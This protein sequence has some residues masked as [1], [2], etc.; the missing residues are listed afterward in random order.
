MSALLLSLKNKKLDISAMITILNH[1]YDLT[2]YTSFSESFTDTVS[3]LMRKSGFYL[4]FKVFVLNV[5]S[6]RIVRNL[7]NSINR[8]VQ[9]YDCNHLAEVHK[10]SE[11]VRNSYLNLLENIIRLKC[12]KFL[13]GHTEEAVA[14]W[15]D[16]VEDTLIGAD[17]EIRSLI[18]EIARRL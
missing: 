7:R 10:F 6:N 15:D 14:E 13:I 17:P 18:F 11:V 4:V 3:S 1:H 16:L 2:E 5:R 9:G 12:P 8:S